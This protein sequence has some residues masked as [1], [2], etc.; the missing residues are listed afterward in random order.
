MAAG[1]F[2]LFW[3]TYFIRLQFAGNAPVSNYFN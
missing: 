1:Y 2:F 3:T